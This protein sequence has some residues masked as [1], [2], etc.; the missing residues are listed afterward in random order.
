MTRIS[1]LTNRW[2]IRRTPTPSRSNDRASSGLPWV[3]ASA[4][5][6]TSA[7]A[8]ASAATDLVDGA[9]V[10]DAARGGNGC[11]AKLDV[12]RPEFLEL[13]LAILRFAFF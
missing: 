13:D 6:A 1:G 9:H 8:A 12:E 7:Q 5:A 4:R 3:A 10:L 11:H 2:S